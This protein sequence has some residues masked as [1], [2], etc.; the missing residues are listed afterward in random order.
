MLRLLLILDVHIQ[1]LSLLK[2]CPLHE[3]LSFPNKFVYVSCLKNEIGGFES[4]SLQFY[5]YIE[6]RTSH[7]YYELSS[8]LCT[9]LLTTTFL[10]HTPI[11]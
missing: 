10:F 4:I 7:F 5:I 1:Q 6:L 3:H 11:T 2:Y 9:P 8:I